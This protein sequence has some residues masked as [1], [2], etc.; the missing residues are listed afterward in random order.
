VFDGVTVLEGVSDSDPVALIDRESVGDGVAVEE[1]VELMLGLAVHEA[2]CV[3]VRV[4][5]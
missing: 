4:S 1:L 2:D 5:V 3:S